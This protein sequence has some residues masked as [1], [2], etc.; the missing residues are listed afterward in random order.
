MSRLEHL[1][2][3]ALREAIA[4]SPDGRVPLALVGALAYKRGASVAALS[5]RY[6]VSEATVESWFDGLERDGLDGVAPGDADPA[7]PYRQALDELSSHVGLL[8]PGG[9]IQF[10][11]EPLAKLA[12]HDR[13]ELV[14]GHLL[15]VVHDADADRVERLLA[16]ARDER[17]RRTTKFGLL[18]A[19]GETVSATLVISP[20]RDAEDDDRL[21]AVV[22]PI[23][24]ESGDREESVANDRFETLVSAAPLAVV[25]INADGTIESWNPAAERTFGW[26]ES[27]VLGATP[28]FVPRGMEVAWQTVREQVFTG[29]TVTD[30]EMGWQTMDGGLVD[31][32]LSAA[33]LKG[34]DDRVDGM[35]VVVT[36]ITEHREREQRLGV[37]DRVLRHN[38]RNDM[39]VII[40]HAEILAAELDD[41]SVE[42]SADM[43]TRKATEVIELADKARDIESILSD[44]QAVEHMDVAP[45]VE[46][47]AER[48]RA[49]HPDADID[50]DVS[51]PSQVYAID[52]IDLAIENLVEN[53]IVHNDRD[54]PEVEVTVSRKWD[55][56]NWVEVQVA[57]DGPGIP[58]QE[59]EV[60][61]EG[62]ESPLHHASR[63]GLWLVHWIVRRSAGELV[64]S[65]NAPRGSVVTIRLQRGESYTLS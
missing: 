11:N 23:A 37:L 15:D 9:T 57:D 24:E 48:H 38:M 12:G 54:S 27:D 20:L 44:Q 55:D 30:V 58:E 36:D 6:G 35:L 50:V 16:E 33:P 25:T 26:T 62:R 59:R 51:G 63:L 22:T 8:A 53:A 32:R 7:E 13:G 4:S 47:I 56:R 41:P 64:F 10:V 14:G 34:A 43:I 40:G 21:L 3:E 60:L 31:V 1:S 19:T 2:A 18:C 65:E 29:E 5:D 28:P 17:R 49:E 45:V 39:N 42:E 46:D 52:A 61:L